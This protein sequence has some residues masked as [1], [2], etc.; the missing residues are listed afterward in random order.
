MSELRYPVSTLCGDYARAG[1][2]LVLTAGPLLL[3]ELAQ[4][5]AA[6]LGGLA[7][8]FLWFALR[9][10]LRQLTW[11]ELSPEA[12]ARSGPLP[13]RLPWA[14][15]EQV[16]LAYYAPRRA[17]GGG[18]LQLTLRGQGGDTIRVDSTLDGFA[19]VLERTRSAVEARALPLDPTTATN[20]AALGL[21]PPAAAAMPAGG[22][23][24]PMASG[25]G[26]LPA[27]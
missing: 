11:I 19:D 1:L 6:L 9:T 24:A 7:L 2:G 4:V 25:S 22:G 5:M 10:G 27:R 20:F 13:R 16:R 18:W 3:L 12:I 17:Q 15:L 26:G 14:R 23:P 8:L 21:R